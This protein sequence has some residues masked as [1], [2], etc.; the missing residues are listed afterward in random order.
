MGPE[1]RNPTFSPSA[2]PII[3]PMSG[4]GDTGLRGGS[5]IQICLVHVY[6]GSRVMY[7]S[8]IKKKISQ[9]PRSLSD[10]KECQSPAGV[11]ALGTAP[12]SLPL[13]R[14]LSALHLHDPNLVATPCSR[15]ALRQRQVTTGSLSPFLDLVAGP[16]VP[17]SLRLLPTDVCG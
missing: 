3:Q 5:K 2:Q 15:P 14:L 4:G 11:P 17:G 6:L 8:G 1:L 16:P 13:P 10:K 12:R 7:A 9:T